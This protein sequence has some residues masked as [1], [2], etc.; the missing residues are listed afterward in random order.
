MDYKINLSDG[1]EVWMNSET[2][3][4]F[5]SQFSV[6]KREITISGEAYI[7]VAKN[8]RV[9]FFV[10]LPNSSI[11]VTGT[12]FNVNTYDSVATNV[13]LIEGGLNLVT[14]SSTVKIN[15]GIMALYN[16]RSNVVERKKFNEKRTL[17]WREGIFYFDGASLN[18][19]AKVV[20]RWYGIKTKIDRSDLLQ[21][22]F[23]GMLNKHQ[24]IE[25]FLD[26]LK[27]ISQ[28]EGYFDDQQILHFK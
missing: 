4:T 18:D 12:E 5:P 25:I 9:P 22:R 11:Q 14:K 6:N 23:A 16:S 24:S 21:K 7:R 28:I 20:S 13:A 19:I 17:S 27:T 15:P 26:N 10:K 2:L 1:S 3:L 8:S